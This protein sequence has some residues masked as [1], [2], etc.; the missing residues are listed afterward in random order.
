MSVIPLSL[1]GLNSLILKQRLYDYIKKQNS[2]ICCL[3]W[4]H[5]KHNE[6]ETLKIKQWEKFFA[7]TFRN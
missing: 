1:N 7:N 6:K 2:T 4:T 5:I 3:Q